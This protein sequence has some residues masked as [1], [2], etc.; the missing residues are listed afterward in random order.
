MNRST[1]HHRGFTII[2]LLVVIG[3]MVANRQN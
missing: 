1:P 2:E 3:L